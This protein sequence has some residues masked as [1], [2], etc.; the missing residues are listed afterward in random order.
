VGAE[1]A[2]RENMTTAKDRTPI[3]AS[4]KTEGSPEFELVQRI[5][6]TPAFTRS[7]L[8]TRFLLY[9]CDCK[10]RGRE[11]EI[12]EH[13]I[14]V[15]ALRRPGSYNPGE[16]NIVRNYARILRN[17]LDEFFE[18]EGRTEALR[19]VIPRG[20]YVPIFE[21]NRALS[22]TLVVEPEQ[23]DDAEAPS[24]LPTP[25][26]ETISQR[27]R[28][29][30]ISM[31]SAAVLVLCISI[32][33]YW[34]SRPHSSS[35]DDLFWNEFFSSGR[36]TYLVPGDS[37]L[38]ML[39]DIT[40]VEVHLNDYIA[41]NL[42]EK[43]PALNFALSHK[44]GSYGVDRFSNYTSTADLSI[45]LGIANR[46]QSYGRQVTVRYARDMHM[47]EFK[48][49]NVLLLGGRHANPW[50]ELFE[51]ESNF[52]MYFPMHLDGMHID[53]RSFINLNPRAGE[54]S[55]YTNFTTN[56]INHTYALISFFPGADGA[57]H[58]LLLQG[59]NMA[60]TQAAGDFLLNRSA[61]DPVLKKAQA[62]DGHVGPFEVLLEARTVGAN[63]PEAHVLVE[64]T[65]VAKS[66]Q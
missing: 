57:G 27:S 38:A 65:G 18:G 39:Q 17:R 64:R 30:W 37:G 34:I 25:E 43:F 1:A 13:R 32:S 14:G 56:Q 63:A 15:Q 9:V 23:Q 52:R 60:A 40:E 31:V 35:V 6:A 7:V 53:P 58:V 19:I 36:A 61:M 33:V 66:F 11:E 49:S 47:E 44:G 3:P 48:N 5:I 24:A 2:G 22:A 8:L 41:G 4:R 10:L 29:G 28:F 42:E 46:A 20:H 55:T 16:D 12:T 50:V 51:P 59:E 26:A 45:A 54:Q 21:P 62:A